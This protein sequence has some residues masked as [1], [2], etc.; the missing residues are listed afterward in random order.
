LYSIELQF[1]IITY[2][3]LAEFCLP[4]TGL[5]LQNVQ[6]NGKNFRYEHN[7][8]HIALVSVEVKGYLD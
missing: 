2:P 7:F 4:I 8:A 3:M 5:Q 6:Q 1:D